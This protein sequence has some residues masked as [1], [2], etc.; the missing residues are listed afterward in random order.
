[1]ICLDTTAIIDFLNGR[2]EAVSAVKKYKGELATTEINVFETFFGIYVKRTLS[3]KEENSAKEFFDSLDILP[4][5]KSSG[6]LAAKILSQLARKGDVIGQNDCMTATI[7]LKNGCDKILTK[8]KK[9]FSKI[10]GL[11]VVSY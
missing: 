3:E 10:K 6:S 9:H 11:K 2:D 5:K 4:M 1:M 7:M 8:N